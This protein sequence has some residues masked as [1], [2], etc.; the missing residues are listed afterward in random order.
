MPTRRAFLVGGAATAATL[1]GTV[2]AYGPHRL[3]HRLGL[4]HSPDRHAPP[5]GWSIV[6]GHLRSTH[7]EGPVPWAM[8]RPPGDQPLV[9]AVICLHGRG[10]DHRFA[11]DAVHLHEAAAEAGLRLGTAAIDGSAP[12]YGHRRSD[13]TDR[14]AMVVDDFVPLVRRRFGIER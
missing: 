1:A 12:S 11:F 2:G 5:S 3:L 8:S 6:E 13:G 10:E 7:V 14:G 4:E 9:G